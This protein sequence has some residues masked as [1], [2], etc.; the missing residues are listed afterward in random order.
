MFVVIWNL[1]WLSLSLGFYFQ[2]PPGQTGMAGEDGLMGA[3]GE[4]GDKSEAGPKGE[5]CNISCLL[6]S[7]E[8]PAAFVFL[9]EYVFIIEE[10]KKYFER[11]PTRIVM[12]K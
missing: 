5:V 2:G 11:P 7:H 3:P 12:R 6:P 4:V 8:S 9:F 10:P 1:I